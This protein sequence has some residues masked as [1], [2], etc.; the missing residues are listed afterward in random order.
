MDQV[1]EDKNLGEWLNE[2]Y[3][4][5]QG[6]ANAIQRIVWGRMSDDMPGLVNLIPNVTVNEMFVGVHQLDF[7]KEAKSGCFLMH[8]LDR[9][10]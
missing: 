8:L 6:F 3:P 9:Y 1:T 5:K 2:K 10:L 4:E 7:S